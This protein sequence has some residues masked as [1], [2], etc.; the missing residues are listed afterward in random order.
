M[1]EET[2]CVIPA[3]LMQ[4]IYQEMAERTARDGLPREL[5]SNYQQTEEP[6][7]MITAHFGTTIGESLS[8]KFHVTELE[9]RTIQ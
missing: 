5:I 1:T 8:I 7:G 9:W 4:P 6:D 2:R 3:H